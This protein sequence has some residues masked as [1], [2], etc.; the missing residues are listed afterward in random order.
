MNGRTDLPVKKLEDFDS[1]A[2]ATKLHR[3]PEVWLGAMCVAALAPFTVLIFSSPGEDFL[4]WNLAP[5]MLIFFCC[6][7]RRSIL[8]EK[9]N[10]ELHTRYSGYLSSVDPQMLMHVAR[11]P[12]YDTAS[13]DAVVSYLNSL[14][15]GWSMALAQR[16]S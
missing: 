3:R 6:A 12:E 9:S 8:V 16:L 15:P 4:F 14:H 10:A 5:A 11:S 13:R 7:I 1:P 2:T